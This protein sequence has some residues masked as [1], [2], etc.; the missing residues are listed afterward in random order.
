MAAKKTTGI[1]QRHSRTCTRA[2]GCDCPWRAEIFDPR[3]L[4]HART[5]SSRQRG[6]CNCTPTRG[7]KIRKTFPKRSQAKDWRHDASSALRRGTM[8]APTAT[9]L[10]EAW[11]AW[12]AGAEEGSVRTR[13]GDRYKPSAI[14]SYT[15]SMRLRVLDDLGGAKLSAL[16]R[17]DLQDLADRLLAEGLDPSTIR[18]A[19]MPLRVVFRRAVERGELGVNPATGIRLPAVRGR[20]E[21]FAGPDEAAKLIEAVPE[22]DRAIWATAA[23]A[24]LR[25]GELRAL[26]HGDVDLEAGLIRV[27]RSWDPKEGPIEPKSRAGTRTVPI[28]AAL[29]GHLAAHL[30]RQRRRS[31]LIFGRTETRPFDDRALAIRATKAWTRAEL[32]PITLHELRH[33]CASIFIAAGVNAKALSSYLGHASV[34][35]TYDRYGHLMPGSEDEAVKLVDDYIERATGEKAVSGRSAARN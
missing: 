18:N 21:R 2:S 14:R 8:R 9:T 19:L 1:T 26:E 23:Y 29:R 22:D 11:E 20:R 35:I 16:T 25:L 7:A 31:G 32:T 33:S 10:R 15:T 13:S 5:C 6:Q 24:G 3:A 34:T 30:L 28:V 17:L 4:Q 27:Q 12:L